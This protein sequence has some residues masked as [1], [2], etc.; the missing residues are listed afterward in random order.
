[1]STGS[2]SRFACVCVVAWFVVGDFAMYAVVSATEELCRR[3]G[4]IEVL[5]VLIQGEGFRRVSLGPDEHRFAAPSFSEH[6]EV[7]LSGILPV[8]VYLVLVH[9]RD[10]LSW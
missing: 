8:N 9:L 1:M 6:Q 4:H 5:V 10:P 7:K 2:A 3:L